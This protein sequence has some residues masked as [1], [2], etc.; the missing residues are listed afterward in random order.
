MELFLKARLQDEHWSLVVSKRQEPDWDRFI[1]GDFQSVSIEE[2]LEKL[3]KVARVTIGAETKE[4]LVGLTRHRNKMVHFFHEAHSDQKSKELNATIAKEQ[5]KV[6]YSVYRLL[7]ID[8]KESFIAWNHELRQI[9]TLFKKHRDYLSVI[10]EAIKPQ[11][12]DATSKGRRFKKCRSCNFESLE[13]SESPGGP[14]SANCLVCDLLETTLTV[15]CPKC[16]NPISFVNEG[17]AVCGACG[18]NIEPE[19]LTSSFVDPYLA[20]RAIK[21]GD[22]SYDLGNC[23]Q[24]DGYHTVVPTPNGDYFCTNCFEQFDSLS[25]CQWCGE[26]NTGDMDL[27]G[28][29]GC[30][31]CDGSSNYD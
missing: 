31:H 17:F 13:F 12:L 5:L 29:D 23:A 15:E 27:S 11:I 14:F 4:G 26:P 19:D 2:A 28:I 16:K 18:K 10:F 6:W 1:R 9:D 30:S 21:D 3:K 8:W 22:N 20:H 24:C 7:T 25:P